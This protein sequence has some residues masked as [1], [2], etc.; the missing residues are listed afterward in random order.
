MTTQI[1]FNKILD[2]L[3]EIIKWL[4]ELCGIY[5]L[6]II[7]HYL[8]GLLYPIV[9]TPAGGIGFIMSP[10]LAVTPYCNALRWTIYTGGNIITNMWIILGTWL[11]SQLCKRLI[12][13][14]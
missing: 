4:L 5:L 8:S 3:L 9:C 10:F 13:Q 12:Q 1:L 2:Y 6:W 11:A 7:I 14:K